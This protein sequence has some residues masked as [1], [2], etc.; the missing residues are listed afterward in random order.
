MEIGN[1]QLMEQTHVKSKN[2][3][4]EMICLCKMTEKSCLL[5]QSAY[6]LHGV[7]KNGL[8]EFHTAHCYFS[9]KL[10]SIIQNG[11]GGEFPLISRVSF[12]YNKL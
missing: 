11:G 2:A 12:C 4:S 10:N 8:A 7:F 5:F 3:P 9:F 1:Y 6:V